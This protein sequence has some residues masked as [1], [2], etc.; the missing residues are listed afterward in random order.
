MNTIMQMAINPQVTQGVILQGAVSL[1]G[2]IASP[3]VDFSLRKIRVFLAQ[4]YQ[5]KI[6]T[7]NESVFI[8]KSLGQ[9]VYNAGQNSFFSSL[10]HGYR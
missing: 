2:I 7:G 6:P 5:L 1:I 10:P 9:K 3:N 4:A 8:D